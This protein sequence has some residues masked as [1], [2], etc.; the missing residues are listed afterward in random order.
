[1]GGGLRIRAS[2]ALLAALLGAC[3][4]GRLDPP[5]KPATPE[6][7]D[8][9]VSI[10][11]D[12]EAAAAR[13]GVDLGA[14]VDRAVARVVDRFDVPLT[15]LTVRVRPRAAIPEIG[16][17][18]FTSLGTGDVTISVDP[19]RP[20]LDEGLQLWLPRTVAHEL[21]HAER[22]VDGPGYGET[23]TE[24][25]VTEGL[26]DAFTVEVIPE[27]PAAPW[28]RALGPGE[29][30]RWWA[31]AQTIGRYDHA[32]WFFGSGEVP[33]WTGYSIG[34]SLVRAY[35]RRH[36]SATAADLAAVPAQRIIHGAAFCR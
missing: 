22:I 27:T 20:D 9:L 12:A 16:V 13:A 26:A 33:R 11:G 15:A 5:Q 34:F 31:R 32:R 28:T 23:L 8:V 35:L 18:G 2:A 4:A 14:V 10:T 7:S 3:D 6:T 36:P 21:H 30:C 17:G 25:I 1:M 29:V 24:A 19:R